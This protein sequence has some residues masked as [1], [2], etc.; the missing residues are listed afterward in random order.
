MKN[1]LKKISQIFVNSGLIILLALLGA[2]G[3]QG[4]KE[5]RRYILPAVV[6]FYSM[7]LL[8]NLWVL[9]IYSLSG[10]LSIGYGRYDQN[11]NKPSF[12]GK[13]A[14]KL[15]P[16]SQVLQDIM[17]R[18]IVGIL[19]CITMLSVPI[20]TWNWVSYLLGS[21]GIILVWAL[22]SWRGFGEIPIK[23]FGKEYQLLNVDLVVYGVTASAFVLIINGWVG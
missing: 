5:L 10:V 6:T 2:V 20:L 13:V 11:D 3:G 16:Q 1:L 9:T 14:Y 21:G 22:V 4:P 8:Q 15:F 23:L 18:G 7:F 12:L 19:I 17:I